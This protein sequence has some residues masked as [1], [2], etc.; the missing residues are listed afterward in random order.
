MDEALGTAEPVGLLAIQAEH[1]DRRLAEL[2]QRPEGAAALQKQLFG[3]RWGAVPREERRAAVQRWVKRNGA[4]QF[5]EQDL[6]AYGL[7]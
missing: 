3:E 4:D 5:L 1:A 6:K 7:I 2:A